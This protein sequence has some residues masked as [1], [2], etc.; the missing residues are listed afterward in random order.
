MGGIIFSDDLL[1]I[2]SMYNTHM[3]YH[4]F[5]WLIICIRDD[6]CF[7][8]AKITLPKFLFSND[9]RHDFVVNYI[10]YIRICKY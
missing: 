6:F 5:V 8:H 9:K 10:T 3:A 7:F 1:C 4:V 2:S